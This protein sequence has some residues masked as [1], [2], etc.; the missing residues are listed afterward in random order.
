MTEWFIA[1]AVCLYLSAYATAVY[2]RSNRLVKH[3]GKAV[4]AMSAL[5]VLAPMTLIGHKRSWTRVAFARNCTRLVRS[6]TKA[7]GELVLAAGMAFKVIGQGMAWGWRRATG[8]AG[9][10]KVEVN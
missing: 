4:V 8:S 9:R 3:G 7:L 6:T 2:C 1:L 10:K 5:V